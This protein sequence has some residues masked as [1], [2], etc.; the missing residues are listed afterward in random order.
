MSKKRKIFSAL[1][2]A[3][4]LHLYLVYELGGDFIARNP[5]PF[6]AFLGYFLGSGVYTIVPLVCAF[7]FLYLIKMGFEISKNIS[8]AIFA[9]LYG[10]NLAGHFSNVGKIDRDNFMIILLGLIIGV[11]LLLWLATKNR[12][13]R[14]DDE[15]KTLV[16][17]KNISSE[18]TTPPFTE[19]YSTSHEDQDLKICPFCAEE[20]RL[21]AIKCKHCYSD[22]T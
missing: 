5:S 9:I 7:V 12:D 4:L 11:F 6:K 20:I 3:L 10:S 17:D 22:L 16:E 1:I 15:F 13:S 2:L 19:T 14:K 18:P 21:K 8:L